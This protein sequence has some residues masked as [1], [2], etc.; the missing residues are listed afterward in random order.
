MDKLDLTLQKDQDLRLYLMIGTTKLDQKVIVIASYDLESALAKAR[1]SNPECVISYKGQNPL[2]TDLLDKIKLDEKPQLELKIP[3]MSKESFI[4]S[5]MLA[6]DKFVESQN[7]KKSL[8]RI[9]S[10]VKG[11]GLNEVKN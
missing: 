2:A 6:G 7:D 8:K 4:T 11:T 9:L 5:L 3:E 1:E 10:K